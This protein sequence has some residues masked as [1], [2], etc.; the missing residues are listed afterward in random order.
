VGK[1]ARMLSGSF[2]TVQAILPTLQPV[3]SAS[4]ETTSDRAGGLVA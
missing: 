2:N 4:G 3:C 1:I